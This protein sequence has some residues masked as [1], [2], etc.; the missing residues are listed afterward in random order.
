MSR[1]HLQ[2]VLC[3]LKEQE[4]E[5]ASLEQGLAGHRMSKAGAFSLKEPLFLNFQPWCLSADVQL[6]I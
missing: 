2:T 5:P 4:A 3:S 1:T 6:E